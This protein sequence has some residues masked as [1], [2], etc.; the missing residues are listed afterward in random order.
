MNCFGF[1]FFFKVV[2]KFHYKSYRKRL[3]IPRLWILVCLL[4]TALDFGKHIG[5]KIKASGPHP[6]KLRMLTGVS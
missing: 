1:F 2:S 4:S 6:A 3:Y 5:A